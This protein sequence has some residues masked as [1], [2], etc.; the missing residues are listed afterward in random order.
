[1]HIK[2]EVSLNRCLLVGL[3]ELNGTRTFVFTPY[4]QQF[5]HLNLFVF[6][7]Y[8]STARVHHHRR[9][10]CEKKFIRVATTGLAQPPERVDL[11]SDGPKCCVEEN[12]EH[13]VDG[14]PTEGDSN[15]KRLEHGVA[16]VGDEVWYHVEEDK[17]TGQGE[18]NVERTDA[19]VSTA[20]LVLKSNENI[21]FLCD[22]MIYIIRF[23]YR[24]DNSEK[25]NYWR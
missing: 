17:G 15:Q 21:L 19:H 11:P 1:M 13:R 6:S 20:H 23:M 10:L 24:K 2:S 25:E 8:R 14:Q 16:G 12:I 5:T 4:G 3:P 22:T 9:R 18:S 7:W